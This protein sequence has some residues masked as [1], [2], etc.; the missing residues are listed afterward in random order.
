MPYTEVKEQISQIIDRSHDHEEGFLMNS[1]QAA[2]DI[3]TYMQ[4]EDLISKGESVR[5][6]DMGFKESG[7]Y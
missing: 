7:S 5:L 1:R 6:S 4:K 3:I 2:E